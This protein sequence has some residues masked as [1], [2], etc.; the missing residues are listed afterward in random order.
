MA[1]E[2]AQASGR[3]AVSGPTGAP[4]GHRSLSPPS[5]VTCNPNHSPTPP[6]PRWSA[7]PPLPRPLLAQSPQLLMP[8]FSAPIPALSH[9]P[10]PLPLKST[11]GASCLNFE[12]IHIRREIEIHIRREI[13][14][15]QASR[16]EIITMS[17]KRWRQA[18]AGKGSR[19]RVAKGARP[20]WRLSRERRCSIHQKREPAVG[21]YER[22]KRLRVCDRGKKGGEQIQCREIEGWGAGKKKRENV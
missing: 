19:L 8:T 1:D 5:R 13:N 6:L 22:S 20:G 10:P 2:C 15:I 4:P 3:P 12:E 7:I 9:N 18:G 17:P 21:T 14:T 11:C 16:S